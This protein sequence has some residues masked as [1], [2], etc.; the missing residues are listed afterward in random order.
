MVNAP[1]PDRQNPDHRFV[2]LD[3]EVLTVAQLQAEI[4]G[5]LR[6][7]CMV[8]IHNY[9][10]GALCEWGQN[11]VFHEICAEDQIVEVQGIR[12]RFRPRVPIEQS[13][14]IILYGFAIRNILGERFPSRSLL[15]EH[16]ILPSTGTFLIA[17]RPSHSPH[18]S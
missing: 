14:Q 17:R 1:R 12:L 18:Q 9:N 2:E 10:E 13:L 16:M 6:K 3:A 8:L 4:E 15:I 5:G 11:S 7:N